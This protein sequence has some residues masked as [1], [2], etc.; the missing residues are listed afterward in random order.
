MKDSTKVLGALL[1]GAAVGI[2]FAPEKGTE[3]RKKLKDSGDSLLDELAD[4]INEGKKALADLTD[5]V[6]AKGE[7]M[8]LKN[9][10]HMD[11]YKH[12]AKP[13]TH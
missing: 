10:D 4:K 1:L 2:L 12:K 5:K 9:E 13:N 6:V 8:K 7:E 3:I 11:G